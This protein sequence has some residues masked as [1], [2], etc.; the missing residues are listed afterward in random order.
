MHNDIARQKLNK[1]EL[2]GD[3]VG[4]DYFSNDCARFVMLNFHSKG[5]IWRGT[6][7]IINN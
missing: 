3:I 4:V 2:H 5:V 6:V 7:T 1:A